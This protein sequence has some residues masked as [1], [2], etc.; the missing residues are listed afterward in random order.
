M[1]SGLSVDGY[2]PIDMFLSEE[3]HYKL[4]NLIQKEHCYHKIQITIDHKDQ[5]ETFFITNIYDNI[6][7]AVMEYFTMIEKT[8][9]AKAVVIK[10]LWGL[11]FRNDKIV[12]NS[13]IYSIKSIEWFIIKSD[14]PAIKFKTKHFSFPIDLMWNSFL[15][16]NPL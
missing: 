13:G 10:F 8:P 11:M 2:T 4:D 3:D 12:A 15:G 7:D 6:D 16:A 9:Y 14:L 5:E 1:T